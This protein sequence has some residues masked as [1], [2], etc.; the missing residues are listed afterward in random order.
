VFRLALAILLA[1][2]LF[3]TFTVLHLVSVTYFAGVL[4]GLLLGM[5]LWLKVRR[6]RTPR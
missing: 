2:L 4:S 6:T 5:V 3:T 1:G